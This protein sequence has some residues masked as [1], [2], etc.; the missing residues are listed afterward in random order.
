MWVGGGRDTGRGGGGGWEKGMKWKTYIMALATIYCNRL[1]RYFYLL[2]TK[3][4]V[5]YITCRKSPQKIPICEDFTNW[6]KVIFLLLF[7]SKT[8][9]E[10]IL[11]QRFRFLK[12][13][14]RTGFIGFNWVGEKVLRGDSTLSPISDKINSA[15][16][17]RLSPDNL[18]IGKW[19]VLAFSSF[20]WFRGMRVLLLYF[21]LFKIA[22]LD[23]INEKF[24]CPSPQIKDGR[25]MARFRSSRTFMFDIGAIGGFCCSIFLILFKFVDIARTRD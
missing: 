15:P 1:R 8:V 5:F 3:E 23:K 14:L 13:I 19:R 22:I 6:A 4:L 9:I 2:Y 18:K 12:C 25:K 10:F 7:F 21:F 24:R 20:P 16:F 17:P 11:I